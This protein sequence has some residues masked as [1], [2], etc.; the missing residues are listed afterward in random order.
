MLPFAALSFIIFLSIV[1][2]APPTAQEVVAESSDNAVTNTAPSSSSSSQ[3]PSLTDTLNRMDSSL[4]LPYSSSS[5]SS[6]N[7]DESVEARR[8]RPALRSLENDFEGGGRLW[9]HWK[10]FDGKKNWKHAKEGRGKRT[11]NKAKGDEKKRGWNLLKQHGWNHGKF[12]PKETYPVDEVAEDGKDMIL[13]EPA[14]AV[15]P[16]WPMSEDTHSK[17]FAKGDI[18]PKYWDQ[19]LTDPDAL[20]GNWQI[21]VSRSDNPSFMLAALGLDRRARRIVAIHASIIRMTILSKKPVHQPRINMAMYLPMGIVK[22]ATV[23]FNGKTVT[24]RDNRL[25]E[26]K[27]LPFF[28]KGRAMQRRVNNRGVFYD[29]RCALPADPTGRISGKVMLVRWTYVSRGRSPIVVNRWLRKL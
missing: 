12:S 17:L 28:V 5:T 14:A 24:Q 16:F 2:V 22:Q 10:L 27:T 25:G 1:V 4:A 8:L 18:N 19:C 26:W 3:T 6:G 29:V 7:G 9:H 21:D 11:W 15:S 13:V 23:T 20:A